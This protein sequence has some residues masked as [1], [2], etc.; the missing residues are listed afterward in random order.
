MYIN[1]EAC[2]GCG[3]C[4]IYCP[5]KAISRRDSSV[6]IDFDEC[7]E[8]N[9]CLRAECCPTDAIKESKLEWP[10]A[11][12]SA[13]SNPIS[14]DD[15]TG[16][17]GRGTAEMKTNEVTGR[18][19]F[20]YLGVSVE[21]GRPGIGCRVR[22]VEKIC[23]SVAPLGIHF[24]PKNPVTYIM[25]D[26]ATGKLQPE[27][28]SEKCLSM[29][30]EFNCPIERLKDVIAKLQ[31]VSREIDTVFSLGFAG[32]VEEDGTANYDKILADLGLSTHSAG[33]TNVGLGRPLN[34]EA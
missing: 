27:T 3:N 4:I 8:C 26:T 29:I 28:L 9:C 18:I 13:L 11:L 31:K 17:S 20:G 21:V 25:T 2:V 34:K 32:R 6:Q 14:V 19:P 16:V 30:I 22:D 5:V 10:R 7:V 12:R 1:E 33:K 24:E 15:R 23:M